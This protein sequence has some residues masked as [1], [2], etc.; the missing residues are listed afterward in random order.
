LPLLSANRGLINEAA[1]S[2]SLSEDEN[3]KEAVRT[4][5]E[6][7]DVVTNMANHIAELVDQIARSLAVIY[8]KTGTT[9]RRENHEKEDE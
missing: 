6:N 7:L 3:Q 9:D 8:L 4:L 1:R 2:K 5:I